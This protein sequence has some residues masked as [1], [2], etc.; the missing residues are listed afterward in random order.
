M[1][2]LVDCNNFYASCERVFRPDL[3]EEP[4]V[5]LSNNDGCVIARSNEAKKLGIPMG[6]P[7]FKYDVIFKKNSISV[8]SS[9]YALYGDMSN[10]VMTLLS[11]FAPEIE[12]YSIDEA[13]LKYK[14]C[15][16]INFHTYASNIK[17]IVT[18]STGIPIS[19]GFAPTKAL[20]KVANKIAKKFSYNTQNV[21]IIDS[22]D[23]RIKALKWLKVEDIWGIGNN[24]AKYLRSHGV[25]NAFQ[26]SQLPNE[27]VRKHMSVTSLRLKND[28]EGIPTL[29][30]EKAKPKKNIATTRTFDKNHSDFDTIK[31][32]VSTFSISCAEK[33]RKQ[34]S[35][36]NAL[37]VFLHTNGHRKD[38]AQYKRNIFIKTPFPT[39]SS[40]EISSF[41]IQGLKKIYKKGYQYKKA[42]VIVMELTPEEE[43]QLNLFNNSNPKHKKLMY[44]VD[45]LNNTIGQ[46][47]VKLGSQDLERTWKM[48]Q[49]KLS[50]R[51]T[52]QLNEII[53]V[54]V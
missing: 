29:N 34:K 10:R 15:E 1:F 45:K 28:L 24:H 52:T 22:E 43:Q 47:K 36:C 50:P 37:M 14:N 4:I 35:N 32:R 39:N 3:N 21:Y 13:F 20:A 19:I 49:E 42:G 38:L 26:F 48:R 18:K 51:Y 25:S 53:K 8:F 41:A 5:V 23:K 6:A 44:I 33:L 2:A 9:N 27:W 40:I 54:K 17:N 11:S 16:H 12:V 7:A 46:N 31:E 30:L